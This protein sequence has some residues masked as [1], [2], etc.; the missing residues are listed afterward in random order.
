MF[1]IVHFCVLANL[2]HIDG[3]ELFLYPK[4]SGEVILR[5]AKGHSDQPLTTCLDKIGF[6]C[7]WAGC[8]ALWRIT[9]CWQPHYDGGYF[10][11]MLHVGMVDLLVPALLENMVALF[12]TL[13]GTTLHL[14][15]LINMKTFQKTRCY[16]A[17]TWYRYAMQTEIND[18]NC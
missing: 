11:R 7:C 2:K 6:T 9:D 17:A 3:S 14:Q 1:P 18:S 15:P 5:R 12:L 10:G 13:I 4:P 16:D 8:R